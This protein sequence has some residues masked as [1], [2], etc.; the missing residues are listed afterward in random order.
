MASLAKDP[1]DKLVEAGQLFDTYGDLLTERQRTFM[2]LHFDE[3]LSFSDISREYKITRQA[4]HD[5]VKHAMNALRTFEK[6]LGL[7]S[8]AASSKQLDEKGLIDSLENLQRSVEE[9][10]SCSGGRVI[11]KEIE[12]LMKTMQ[13]ADENK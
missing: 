4:V 8:R 6:A 5:S 11:I 3:D 9:Q 1:E 2:G 7:V 12:S 13:D 10:C